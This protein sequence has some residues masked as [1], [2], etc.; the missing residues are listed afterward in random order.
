MDGRIE[1]GG[2]RMSGEGRPTRCLFS[3][4][5]LCFRPGPPFVLDSSSAPAH[6]SAS[7]STK[8]ANGKARLPKVLLR[9]VCVCVIYIT[10]VG[11]KP[12]ISIFVVF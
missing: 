12:C 11:T 7:L 4:E 8:W 5:A 2:R 1:G 9:S 3:P 10:A 6:R